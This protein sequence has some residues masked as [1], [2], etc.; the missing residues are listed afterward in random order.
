MRISGSQKQASGYSPKAVVNP[1]YVTEYDSKGLKKS[2]CGGRKDAE[3]YGTSHHLL[4]QA[5]GLDEHPDCR[6]YWAS[7]RYH[8]QSAQRGD[9]EEA[10][11]AQPQE[12]RL[13]L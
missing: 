3:L 10:A 6:V 8:C 2:H 9:R 11:E 7:P 5:K 1:F 13:R 4:P 12:R